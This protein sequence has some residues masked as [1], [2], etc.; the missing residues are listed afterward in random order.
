MSTSRS[1]GDATLIVYEDER[2][3]FNEFYQKVDSLDLISIEKQIK[4]GD[5]VAIA[6]RNYPEWLVAFTASVLSGAITVP[7]NS[8]GKADELLHGLGDC[9]PVVLFCDQQRYDFVASSAKSRSV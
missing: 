8:W 1:T 4:N 6:M 9:E 2:W 7:L 5:R 3:T